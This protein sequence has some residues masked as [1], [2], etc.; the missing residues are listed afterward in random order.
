MPWW[1]DMQ[2]F[3]LTIISAFVGLKP[4]SQTT[5]IHLAKLAS[6]SE[7]KAVLKKVMKLKNGNFKES[8]V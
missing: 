2:I 3:Q 4:A 1:E 7:V 5:P 8:R 6:S